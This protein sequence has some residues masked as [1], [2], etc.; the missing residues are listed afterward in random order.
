MGNNVTAR[1]GKYV[2]LR[3]S[4]LGNYVIADKCKRR[5][6][7]ICDQVDMEATPAFSSAHQG[8]D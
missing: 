8:P 6:L 5:K 3:P 1:V 7:E 2:T 4:Q